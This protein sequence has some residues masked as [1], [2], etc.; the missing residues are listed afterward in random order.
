[1]SDGGGNLVRRHRPGKVVSL[2]LVAA[3]FS[4]TV[5]LPLGFDAFGDRSQTKIGG[6]VNDGGHDSLVF[7]IG[8]EALHE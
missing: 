5:E 6:Q 3:E 1:V 7:L 4:H 2:G 8:V